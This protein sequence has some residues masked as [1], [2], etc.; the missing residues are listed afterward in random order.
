[1]QRPRCDYFQLVLNGGL[2]NQLFGFA[3][4]KSIEKA[5]GLQCHFLAPGRNDRPYELSNFGIHCK[6]ES[7]LKRNPFNRDIPNR[8]INKLF[9]DLFRYSE[10]SF[11]YDERFYRNPEGKT[12]RG[13]FQSYLYL[14]NMELELRNLPN[15]HVSFSEQYL[16][17]KDEW[18]DSKYIAVHVRRGDYIGKENYHGLVSRDYLARAKERILSLNPNVEFVVFSDSIEIAK[19]DFPTAIKF[20]SSEDLAKPSENLLLMSSMGGLI[21]SNSS[22]SWWA[23][24][25]NQ[26]IEM[27]VFP[28][29]WFSNPKIDTQDLLPPNWNVISSGIQLSKDFN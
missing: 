27:N 17:L 29:P 11:R 8:L 3:A 1:M 19:K 22:L 13:Y 21:G 20:I 23:G 26:K 16:K 9:P 28:N 24:Y 18:G 7:K 10:T 15:L 12:L 5:T 2:G 25:L 14:K 6:M 4:G